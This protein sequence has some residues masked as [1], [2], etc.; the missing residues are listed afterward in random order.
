MYKSAHEMVA[1][2]VAH[3]ER[4]K[5][6]MLEIEAEILSRKSDWI[7]KGVPTDAASRVEYE[8]KLMA[9][10][11]ENHK[12]KMR[13]AELKGTAK[14]IKT[15]SLVSLLIKHLIDTGQQDAVN[16]AMNRSAKILEESGFLE[17]YKL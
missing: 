8:A 11:V 12:A 4:T 7:S 6:V 16:D 17:A 10:K 9:A 2:A 5:L 15:D 1:E 3:Y 14:K 13:L